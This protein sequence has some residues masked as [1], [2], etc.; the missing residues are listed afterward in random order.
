MI[1]GTKLYASVC[2]FYIGNNIKLLENMKIKRTISW[3]KY[4]S[5]ITAHPKNKNLEYMI[6]PTFSNKP[7]ILKT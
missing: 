2:N 4:R 3:N 7:M 5:E 1:T 6:D